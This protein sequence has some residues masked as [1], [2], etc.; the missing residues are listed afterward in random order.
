MTDDRSYVLIA[1][2]DPLV[3]R[4]ITFVLKKAGFPIRTATDG[5]EA[6][7]LIEEEVPVVALLDVMMPHHDGLEVCRWIK[8]EPRTAHVPVFLV[9]A[10]AMSAERERGLA[11]GADHYVTKPFVNK[12]LVSL[13]R[14]AWDASIAHTG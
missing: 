2:D 14:K 5:A 11:A 3:L 6:L 8:A 13:V 10:R 1:D 4:S 9:T 7:R 12:E